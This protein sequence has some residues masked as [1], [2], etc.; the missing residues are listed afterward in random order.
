MR[1]TSDTSTETPVVQGGIDYEIPTL[2]G[3]VC[4][5]KLTVPM[6]SKLKTQIMVELSGRGI[7]PLEWV[8]RVLRKEL[9][10]VLA[11]VAPKTKVG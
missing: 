3:R 6:E 10:R 11:Q 5:D 2:R 4:N 9:P 1:E 7:D 8:R